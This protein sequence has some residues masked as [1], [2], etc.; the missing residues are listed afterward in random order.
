MFESTFW[1]IVKPSK[2]GPCWGG[3][4]HFIGN[5]NPKKYRVQLVGVL[6]KYSLLNLCKL[7]VC[8]LLLK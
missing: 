5:K 2:L 6:K 1:R 4:F 8:N 7:G 3:Y